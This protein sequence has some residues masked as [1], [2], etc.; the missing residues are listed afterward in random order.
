MK[1]AEQTFL[2]DVASH[3]MEVIHDSPPHRHLRFSSGSSVHH[4][5]I[6]TWPGYLCISGDMGTFVF[7][8]VVDMFEFFR[9]SNDG[10]LRINEHYW[11]EKAK[12]VDRHGG[13]SEFDPEKFRA[14]IE[15]RVADWNEVEDPDPDLQAEVDERVL[16]RIDDGEPEAMRAALDFEHNGLRFDD[17]WEVRCHSFTYRYTWCCYAIAWAIRQYD[18]RRMEDAA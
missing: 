1:C 18:A 6:V 4:F 7:A 14:A 3:R 5:N 11:A 10:P 13:V 17:F 2:T 9:Y 8:R 16:R 15:E 12:A